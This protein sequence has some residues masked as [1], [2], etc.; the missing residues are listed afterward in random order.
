MLNKDVLKYYIDK[1]QSKFTE[2]YMNKWFEP[3]SNPYVE[4]MDDFS[5]CYEKNFYCNKHLD[6]ESLHKVLKAWKN[7]EIEEEITIY[8]KNGEVIRTINNKEQLKA[9][10]YLNDIDKDINILNP[11]LSN[12]DPSHQKWHL[13]V[14]VLAYSI[15]LNGEEWLNKKFRK[16]TCKALRVWM[17]ENCNLIKDKSNLYE[18][19]NSDAKK[20]VNKEINSVF[21]NMMENRFEKF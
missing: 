7:N 5:Y 20:I 16:Y 14:A 17:I 3:K 12:N 9:F 18:L 21:S 15:M 19:I 10:D 4:L 1:N 11:Y 8:D 2:K 6:N 13:Y